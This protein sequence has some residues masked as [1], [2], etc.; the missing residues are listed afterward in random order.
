MRTD[1]CVDVRDASH[2]SGN[3][4]IAIVWSALER[5]SRKSSLGHNRDGIEILR[6][7]VN[8]VRERAQKSDKDRAY[9]RMVL[10]YP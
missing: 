2:A 5:A 7:A 3:A 8:S 9:V 4:F 10:D 6:H 1:L